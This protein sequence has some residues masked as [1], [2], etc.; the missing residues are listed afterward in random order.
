M[1][2]GEFRTN[3]KNK[4]ENEDENNENKKIIDDIELLKKKI[5]NI[6]DI[7]FD[8]ILSDMYHIAKDID[9]ANELLSQ[10]G[11][12]QQ[13]EKLY[14][15]EKNKG[16]MMSYEQSKIYL[17]ENGRD[18]KIAQISLI[19]IKETMGRLSDHLRNQE[20]SKNETD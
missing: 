12:M 3:S 15:V 14:K 6:Q 20:K 4:V 9:D 8:N 18:A 19:S 10:I 5:S 2:Y 16:L 1:G 7:N 17:R 13:F 11:T